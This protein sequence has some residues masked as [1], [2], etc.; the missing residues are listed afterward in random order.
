MTIFHVI[1]I[2]VS[3]VLLYRPVGVMTGRLCT[4]DRFVIL[5]SSNQYRTGCFLIFGMGK[6][7]IQ[8][9]FLENFTKKHEPLDFIKKILLSL[10]IEYTRLSA[11]LS[12]SDRYVY[13]MSFKILT[14]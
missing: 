5:P 13:C 11:G 2:I 9:C 4:I 8:R 1:I 14:Y 6:A 3:Q 10:Q 7:E 12:Y